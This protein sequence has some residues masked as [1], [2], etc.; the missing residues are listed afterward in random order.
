MLFFINTVDNKNYREIPGILFLDWRK[1]MYDESTVEDSLKACKDISAISKGITTDELFSSLD[2]FIKEKSGKHKWE[3]TLRELE[4]DHKGTLTVEISI[5]S[6]KDTGKRRKKIPAIAAK[7][8]RRIIMALFCLT[9][10]FGLASFVNAHVAYQTTIEGESMEP[11]FT[12]NDSVIIQKLSYYLHDP[13]RYD[14]IV[15]PVKAD[16]GDGEEEVNYIK[17]IIGLPGEIVQIKD[18][19]VY[20]NGNELDGDNYS[21]EE[22][23]DPG[24]VS[25]P[26][27]LAEDEYFVLGDNRNMSTDS[28]YQL[29]GMVKKDNIEGAAWYCIWPF[30][31]I[32]KLY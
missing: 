12:N 10:A 3:D 9:A 21:E 23:I 13:E 17:R 6:I 25:T 7:A 32:K 1:N 5:E 8:V 20:I 31:H 30:S 24:L 27:K 18:G 4:G 19:K 2:L 29:V 15:F 22:I 16:S 28:R 14:V 11:S 26:V